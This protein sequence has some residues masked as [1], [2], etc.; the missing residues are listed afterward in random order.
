MHKAQRGIS[1]IKSPT[2]ARKFSIIIPAA[3]KGTR[4]MSYGIKSL[5]KIRN[6]TIIDRQLRLIKQTFRNYEVILVCGFQADKLMNYTPNDIIK[7][8]NELYGHTNVVRSIG[9]GLRAATTNNVVIM[10]GDLVFNKETLHV[11]FDNDSIAIVTN[12][13]SKDEVGCIENKGFIEHFCYDLPLRWAQIVYLTGAELELMKKMTWDRSKSKM[14]G[15]EILNSMIDKGAVIK[16]VK[17]K[18]CKV[19]DIDSSKDITR[20]SEI[21]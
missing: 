8:E 3:G 11:P 1:A 15:F 5:I 12:T 4:M 16:A 13:M 10:Y 7:V 6:E 9:M 17:P 18:K 20:A 14:F 21:L 2:Q 19:M